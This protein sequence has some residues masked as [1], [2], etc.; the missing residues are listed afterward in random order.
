MPT[1]APAPVPASVKAPA[2]Q[3]AVE[4]RPVATATSVNTRVTV[5]SH[6]AQ[7]RDAALSLIRQLGLQPAFLPELSNPSGGAFFNRLEHLADLQ[8]AIVLLPVNALD[9]A[10]GGLKAL[11][12]G[13]LMEL[14]FLLGTVGKDRV[15]F[16]VPGPTAKPLP[17][18]G[19]A[20]VPMDDAGLW[21]LLLAR[22]MKQAGLDVD[23][24]RAL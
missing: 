24:N 13:L 20:C 15:F 9:A 21:R 7:V 19:V 14:G 16:L 2:P 10:A 12:P 22:A 8:Y 4:A 18:E 5:V 23:L 1:P 11:S 6:D 17:W 3:A